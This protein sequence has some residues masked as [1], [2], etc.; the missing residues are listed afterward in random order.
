MELFLSFLVSSMISVLLIPVLIRS[1]VF[2]HM[3]DEPDE[4]KVHTKAIPRCGGL[5]LAIG[6]IT[7][8]F[9]FIPFA[10]PYRSL[11]I[12]GAIIVFFGV[13]DDVFNLNFKWKFFG[14][15]I[16][17]LV[18][19]SG[20]IYL[21]FLPFAGLDPAPLYIVYPLTVFFVVGVTNAVNLSDGLDGLAAGIMLM[22]VS[23]TAFY[24]A[25]VNGSELT[26]ITLSLAG[27]IIGFLRYNTHP[28][29]VFMGDTG[30][31]FI[32]FMTAFLAI[33]LVMDVHPTLNPALPLLLLGLP[34]LDTIAVMIQRIRCGRS[35]FS[36]DKRHIHHRLLAHGLTHAEAVAAIYIIQSIFL[37]SSFLLRYRSDSL[38]FGFYLM[39]CGIILIFFYWAAIVHWKLHPVAVEIDRRRSF[40]RRFDWLYKFSKFYIEYALAIFI[41]FMI[42]TVFNQMQ[43]LTHLEVLYWLAFIGL[44]WFLNNPLKETLARLGIYAAGIFS[45]FILTPHHE[46]S[47]WTNWA[48]DAYL[49]VLLLVVFLAVRVT[50]KSKFYLTTQDILVGLFIIAIMALADIELLPHIIFRLFCLGYAVEYLFHRKARMYRPL[51]F[52]A[53]LCGAIII[54]KVLPGIV[55][56]S[57]NSL[58]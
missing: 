53:A 43:D 56:I 14:Q 29:I 46:I 6:V 16:A 47:L 20:G 22:S 15:I 51:K 49:L 31:Q 1:S 25:L 50:R 10:E 48:I 33:Y 28:A 3:V 5:G 26:I 32:G 11:L 35:P 37:A 42:F 8:F 34:I 13:L 24:S 41:W 23:A 58:D 7:A 45:S 30:S 18:V 36:P 4:R 54:F 55:Q 57:Q 17:V 9:I 12:G 38:V 40:F 52:S 21:K 39:I 19:M 2:L 27:G 44:F